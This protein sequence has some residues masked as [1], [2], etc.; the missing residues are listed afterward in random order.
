MP[1]FSASQREAALQ[2]LRGINT[3]MV[4]GS[5]VAIAVISAGV[6]SA[7]P[8][9]SSHH[10]GSTSPAGTSTSD[11]TNGQSGTD[12][13]QQQPQQQQ[14]QPAV[15]APQTDVPPVATSGSS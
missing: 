4:A 11:G 9:R 15:Q 14:P 2:R 6:A 7:T 8:G 10:S 5:F 12:P 1:A 3:G 13:S